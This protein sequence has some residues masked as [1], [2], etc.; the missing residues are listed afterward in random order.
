MSDATGSQSIGPLL[1][2]HRFRAQARD[3]ARGYSIS[4]KRL[5]LAFAIEIIVVIASLIGAWLFAQQYGHDDFNTKM[6]MLLAPIGYAVVEFS[7]V[8]LAVSVRT[9]R[10]RLMKLV[11]LI[12]VLCAA[13]VTIKSMSQL[14]EIMFRPRLIDVVRSHEKLIDAQNSQALVRKLIES[15]DDDVERAKSAYDSASERVTKANGELATLPPTKCFPVSGRRKDGSVY[16]TQKC[17]VDGRG[18]PMVENLKASDRSLKDATEKLEATNKIRRE[19]NP[20]EADNKVSAAQVAYKDAVLNSQLHSFTAMVFGKDPTAVT[21]GEIHQF[22]RVFVFFPAIFVAFAS[23]LLAMTSV[24]KIKQKPDPIALPSEAMQ[25]VLGPYTELIMKEAVDAAHRSALD[26]IH[27][28]KDD[29]I[30][31][32]VPA[33]DPQP[34]TGPVAQP[35]PAAAVVTHPEP[36]VVPLKIVAAE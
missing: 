16:R 12:G 29:A 21:D 2:N 1:L 19:L 31:P 27:K 18:A 22:L 4:K 32:D 23:T 33:N 13:G 34:E 9:Q 25:Y 35:S 14:G 5:G 10:S 11:A 8:P 17:V 28:A 6:M 30:G 24:E 7:R 3:E 15:A 20:S 26:T 36:E